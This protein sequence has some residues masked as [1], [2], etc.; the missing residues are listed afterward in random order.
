MTLTETYVER[1]MSN[2]DP[3][4]PP[5]RR[6]LPVSTVQ[7]AAVTSDA[8]IGGLA[9]SPYLLGLVV[10]TAFGI[11]A[12]VYFLDILISGQ[13]QHLKSL[14]DVQ[15]AQMD[16]VIAMHTR[17]FDALL[18]MGNRLSTVPPQQQPTLNQPIQPPS[19]TGPG[20]RRV[21]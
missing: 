15:Q 9:R 21:P 11:G 7:L 18:E 13:Q 8:V 16:K 2:V 5:L 10:L 12:A 14:V 3:P 20:P 6:E 17:E 19:P 4:P 1:S